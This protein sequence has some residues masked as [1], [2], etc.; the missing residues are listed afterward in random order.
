MN[1][2][3]FSALPEPKAPKPVERSEC[4][5]LQHC[6]TPVTLTPKRSRFFPRCST[7]QDLLQLDPIGKPETVACMLH[8]SEKGAPDY[9]PFATNLWNIL[10]PYPTIPEL[11]GKE[12]P[13]VHA[14]SLAGFPNELGLSPYADEHPAVNNAPNHSTTFSST[15]PQGLDELLE[16]GL[17]DLIKV[18]PA[19]PLPLPPSTHTSAILHVAEVSTFLMETDGGSPTSAASDAYVEAWEKFLRTHPCLD[20]GRSVCDPLDVAAVSRLSHGQDSSGP[21]CSTPPAISGEASVPE[22][23]VAQ[24]VPDDVSTATEHDEASVTDVDMHEL[25][26]FD[27]LGEVE[28]EWM[29]YSASVLPTQRTARNSAS[30][31]DDK[32]SVNLLCDRRPAWDD[33]FPTKASTVREWNFDRNE[34]EITSWADTD[35]YEWDWG[36]ADW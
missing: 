5:V 24:T 14:N 21:E 20:T 17:L 3:D 28:D 10:H 1:N 18:E 22:A 31:C 35:G 27:K 33:V 29:L 25:V 16:A 12:V 8:R 9:T 34:D 26:P 2:F 6:R 15:P 32:D 4:R 13:Y 23:T 7:P 19:E 11:D 30:V 36:D